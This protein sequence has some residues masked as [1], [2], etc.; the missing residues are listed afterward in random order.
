MLR[1]KTGKRER[2]RDGLAAAAVLRPGLVRVKKAK[3][4]MAKKVQIEERD[5][6]QG[7]RRR[8]RRRPADGKKPSARDFC[9]SL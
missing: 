6:H 4:G 7:R 3:N 8:R 9:R 5:H 2:E 1:E